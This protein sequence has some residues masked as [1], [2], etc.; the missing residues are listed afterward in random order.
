LIDIH[1]Y[2][3]LAGRKEKFEPLRPG[4]VGLYVCGITSYDY[5]H[6]GHARAYVTFDV[7]RRAFEHFDYDVLY[8]QNFTD[9]DD[10]IIARAAE[11]GVPPEELSRRFISEYFRDMDALNVRRASFYPRV[12]RHISEIVHAVETL[13]EKGA[14]YAEGGSVYFDVSSVKGYAALSGRDTRA[15][16]LR[17]R[18][19]DPN[20]RGPLDFALW[21]ASK[22]GEPQWD[23]PWGHGRPG[24]HLE[25]NVM[26][27]FYLG[28]PFDIHGGGHDLIFPH[29]ENELAIAS[30]LTGPEFVRCW[31]HNGF[32]TVQDEKMSKSVGNI[33][34]VRE[35]LDRFP[36]DVITLFLLS[37]HYR[38]PL[39][40]NSGVLEE[41]AA[42]YSR[43]ASLRERLES[44]APDFDAAH[45]GEGE[46]AKFESGPESDL[47]HALDEAA[48]KFDAALAD[49]FNTPGA[50]AEIYNMVKAG[51]VYASAVESAGARSEL[52][53]AAR[54]LWGRIC[55]YGGVL[56]LAF[57]A[58][59]GA[60][61]GPGEDDSLVQLLVNLRTE[62]RQRKD[63]GTADRI[64]DTLDEA[65][66][67]LK[68]RA[69]GTTWSKK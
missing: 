4:R 59:A 16:E 50:V 2:N 37:T 62:A 56:G 46:G 14:A 18:I 33:T 9:V 68:D 32:V 25:C 42:G 39:N 67:T 40:F 12:T 27:C 63:F 55:D 31:M 48:D 29:H 54:M 6:V 60:A 22:P 34:P 13:L 28:T 3:T 20:K 58:V 51:N 21:K 66:Y 64:R 23:S 61:G 11:G 30:A 35:L 49:D 47:A 36:A 45:T 52:P 5:C 1:I 65:G 10:K 24:W 38:M 8:I 17:S 41:T 69:D 7:V 19:D 15:E 53:G 43:F 44:L 57:P 26:S